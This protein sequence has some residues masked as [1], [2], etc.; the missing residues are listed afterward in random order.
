MRITMNRYKK[1]WQLKNKAKDSLKGKY[2]EAVLITAVYGAFGIADYLISAIIM[3]SGGSTGDTLVRL[4]RMEATT[5]GY[6]TS[7]GIS[8]LTGILLSALT[9]GL[10]LFYLNIA[11][12]QPF[13][14]KDLFVA[15]REQ[16]NKYLLI[17]LVQ[18]LV[19]FFFSI[20]GYACDFFYLIQP[21]YQWMFLS[22]VCQLIGQLVSLPIVLGLSQ[23]YRLMLD[24]PSLSAREVLVRSFGLMRG[25]KG[26][27][28]LLMFSFLPLEIAALFTCGIGYLWLG[29]YMNMTY[30]Y[31]YLD[32]MN[33]AN[34]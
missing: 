12:G 33:P 18:V 17:A 16:P 22:Y 30:T 10:S 21:S 2:S 9:A 14:V 1:R 7:L 4:L 15:F 28:F 25:H 27:L 29:P 19:S 11:C 26:R 13:S 34:E 3:C 32:L 8:F 31:F 24:Y 23:C 20:P 5:S 6:L